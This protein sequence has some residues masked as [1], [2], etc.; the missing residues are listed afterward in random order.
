L[1][2]GVRDPERMR[3]AVRL[4]PDGVIVGSAIIEKIAAE[5]FDG[6]ADLLRELKSVMKSDG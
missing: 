2:Y 4:N 6:L 5:D 3:E 1:G